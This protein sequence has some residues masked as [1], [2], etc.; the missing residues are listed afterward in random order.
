MSGIQEHLPTEVDREECKDT[1]NGM[2]ISSETTT[3]SIDKHKKNYGILNNYVL[4]PSFSGRNVD[5]IFVG[6]K[7]LNLLKHFNL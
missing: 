7:L 1:A 2:G 5:L 3:T 6:Q 4:K